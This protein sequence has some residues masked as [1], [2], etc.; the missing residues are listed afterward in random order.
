MIAN[1]MKLEDLPRIIGI[2]STRSSIKRM[3]DVTKINIG[4]NI[5]FV[6]DEYGHV[7]V[8]P[9]S[10]L[11]PREKYISSIKFGSRLVI[12]IPKDVMDILEIGEDEKILWILDE[13]GN[14]IIKNTFLPTDCTKIILKQDIGAMAISLSHINRRGFTTIPIEISDLFD[15]QIGDTITLSLDTHDNIIVNIDITTNSDRSIQ[16]TKIY[17]EFHIHL[18]TD[19]R[20]KLKIDIED[21][22]LWILNE[23]GHIIIRNTILPNVCK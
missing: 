18:D 7:N 10:P 3:A 19:V 5:L 15:M 6:L 8:R 17:K 9:Y 12:Q 4:D 13:N 16:T 2:Y 23:N 14:I 21:S 1:V 11:M 22:I 20:T